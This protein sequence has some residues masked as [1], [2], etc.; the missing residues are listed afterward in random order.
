[1]PRGGDGLLGLLRRVTL[2]TVGQGAGVF[3]GDL[4]LFH[5]GGRSLRDFVHLA[6][7]HLESLD[8]SVLFIFDFRVPS[9]A[10]GVPA[11]IQGGEPRFSR[12]ELLF[13]LGCVLFG[14]LV[15]RVLPGFDAFAPR[16]LLRLEPGAEFLVLSLEALDRLA[17]RSVGLGGGL[18]L[19]D[20]RR[21]GFVHANTRGKVRRRVT[22]RR[23]GARCRTISAAAPASERRRR[24][25]RLPPGRTHHRGPLGHR[26]CDRARRRSRGDEL[27]GTHLLLGGGYSRGALRG[28]GCEKTFESLL[29]RA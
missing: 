15:A 17:S 20:G 23:R 5:R 22:G 9:L 25:H 24:V 26:G 4:C 3:R 19:L 14:G 21:T 27:G 2:R 16:L 11:F 8:D 13:Q 6:L 1:M 18:A 10:G 12:R 7:E 29:R 28:G